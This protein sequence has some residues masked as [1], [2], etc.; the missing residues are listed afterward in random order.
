MPP[1]VDAKEPKETS[2]DCSKSQRFDR[3]SQGPSEENIQNTEDRVSLQ[4]TPRHGNGFMGYRVGLKAAGQGT[5]SGISFEFHFDADE[6]GLIYAFQVPYH[7][8]QRVPR[9]GLGE[10]LALV[11]RDGDTVDLNPDR[12]SF[13]F[14]SQSLFRTRS[15]Q[16]GCNRRTNVTDKLPDK[17]TDRQFPALAVKSY[18]HGKAFYQNAGNLLI[19][20]DR[21]GWS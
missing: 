13:E 17:G 6:A 7:P 9:N 19:A 8:Q 1:E 15:L 2:T 10:T 4:T 11:Q 18:A 5:E 20:N 21:R 14:V 3:R 16:R 12:I